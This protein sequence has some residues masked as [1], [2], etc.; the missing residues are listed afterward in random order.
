MGTSAESRRE[1]PRARRVSPFT[2]LLFAVR[3]REDISEVQRKRE[4]AHR[5]RAVAGIVCG[6][7]AGAR[8]G[9]RG[10]RPAVSDCP[11][12]LRVHSGARG[13]GGCVSAAF[14][15]LGAEPFPISLL[16]VISDRSEQ[17]DRLRAEI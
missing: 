2:E 12:D 14:K 3:L 8:R 7:G 4:K 16:V 10:G 11:L 1:P 15:H 13:A 17:R 6:R 5:S 9:A